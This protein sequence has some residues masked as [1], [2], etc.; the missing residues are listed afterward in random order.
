MNL[1][2][3]IKDLVSR[4]SLEQLKLMAVKLELDKTGSKVEI[5]TRIAEQNAK[6]DARIWDI[7]SGGSK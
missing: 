7:I 1:S 6:N 4:R 2:V 5:A 3:E